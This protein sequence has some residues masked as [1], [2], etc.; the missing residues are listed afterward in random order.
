MTEEFKVVLPSSKKHPN[1]QAFI[2]SP[3]KRIIVRAGRR[4]GKTVGC[5]TKASQE[6]LKKR[7]ILYA[8][9]MSEQ[10]QRFWTTVCMAFQEPI[11]SGVLYKNETLH[12]LEVP[13]TEIRIRAK[14]AWNADTLRGDY[15]DLLILDE[16]QLM[17]EDTWELVGAPM[18]LDNNGDAIFIY[19]PP[20]LRTRSVTKANDPQHAA[21]L[22]ARAKFQEELAIKEGRV[23]RWKTFTFSS[24]ENPYIS[25]TALSEITQDMTSLAYRMEILA[26]DISEAPGALWNREIIERNREIK[27]AQLDRIVV[28]ID[29]SATS[30]GDEAGIVAAGK[31]QDHGF[32]LEDASLQ[33]SPLTWAKAA[34]VLYHKLKADRIVAEAN[35][36]GE[37]VAAVISQVDSSVPVRLVHA[38]RGKQTRAEPISA[39][40]EKNM[41]H[42]VGKFEKLEDEMCLWVPGD[43]SPNRMDAMVWAL[44]DLLLGPGNAGIRVI[45]GE[46]DKEELGL[47]KCFWCGEVKE[48]YKKDDHAF[49]ANCLKEKE[50]WDKFDQQ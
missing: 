34:V 14:S 35:N 44:T 12:I 8:A 28:S 24:M 41:V 38:S 13:G 6:F 45:G 1:Q 48:C 22:F 2:D 5:A 37:M 29:P 27:V 15:A 19:T 25:K 43:E 4:G 49:C 26:Q 18:L 16:W 33:G 17:N 40:Y 50:E 47:V 21:K 42:H 20:S 23:P 31:F 36:G 32:V 46:D 39:K 7:R 9:P 11:E 10:V 3:A 30:E